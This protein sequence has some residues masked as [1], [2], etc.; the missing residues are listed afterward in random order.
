MK[1]KS[2][3]LEGAERGKVVTRFPPEP[4]GFMHLGHCKASFFNFL[5][6]QQYDGKM[7][8]R[9]DDTNPATATQEFEDAFI[10][11]L[12]L[13][14]ITPASV[15]HTSDHFDYLISECT[16]LITEGH[17]YVDPSTDAEIKAQRGERKFSPF[18]D[19]PP[20]VNLERWQK[21]IDGSDTTSVVRAKMFPD[22]DVG[23]L[24]DP[25]MF[26][27]AVATHYRTADKYKVYPLYDF[28]CPLIDSLEG[29]THAFRSN[30]YHDRDA[31]YKWVQATAGVRPVRISD[32]G[33]LAFSYTLMSK[34]K[35]AWF[36]RQKI[37][38][39][40]NHPAFP[41][42]QGL[43]RR[44]VT[45]TA[46]REFVT[47]QGGS[48]NS[49]LIDS[50]DLWSI[51][52][53]HIDS[54]VPR[55][56]AIV[57]NG[58]WKL[59]LNVT[60]AD[61]KPISTPLYRK[62]LE[63]GNKTVFP[64]ATVILKGS[65]GVRLKAGDRLGLMGWLIA[66]IDTVDASARTLTGHLL[67]SDSDWASAIKVNWVPQSSDSVPITLIDYKTLIT[68]PK[69]DKTE[70]F[71][72]FCNRKLETIESAIGEP[73]LRGLPRGTHIQLERQGYYIVE[74]STSDSLTL[75]QIPEGRAH[76]VAGRS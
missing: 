13:L 70:N 33:R 43:F 32:F 11:D 58:E 7:I 74:S 1:T 61:L 3:E 51:N 38:D 4:S 41:T 60:D 9:F 49:V 17:L 45:L 20:A 18:R 22:S 46:L 55:Y 47:R 6:A 2:L 19:D 28:A 31:L 34:R 69:L 5:T 52:R 75:I 35:L 53:I 59:T 23:C 66:H 37:V 25:N 57:A 40:W 12:K 72:E 16:R 15:T 68:K 65:D 24:R 42:V 56:S 67:H 39:D 71:E 44:G 26:R 76:G 21:M 62:K 10:R 27:S 64:A 48:S 54:I 63:L 73:A 29:I 30:E 36:V 50:N 8:L 14:E